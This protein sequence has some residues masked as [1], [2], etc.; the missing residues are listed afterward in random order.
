MTRFFRRDKRYPDPTSSNSSP[1][2]V[3]P[4]AVNCTAATPT[5]LLAA[6]G[7]SGDDSSKV[8]VTLPRPPFSDEG[9]IS[10]SFHTA[11]RFS[12]DLEK[13]KRAKPS[14]LFKTC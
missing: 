9:E 2:S 10:P 8:A 7:D 13:W 12:A 11:R 4:S 14:C 6:V 1:D 3:A 5:E